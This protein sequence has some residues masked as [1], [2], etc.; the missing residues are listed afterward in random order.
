MDVLG[1]LVSLLSTG[2]C[3]L[4]LLMASYG[5]LDGILTGLTKST[6]HP[7]EGPPTFLKT[8]QHAAYAFTHCKD[9][10][11]WEHEICVSLL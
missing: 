9:V 10:F 6:D 4:G 8:L 11:S 3:L 7:R 2:P 5:A 1:D